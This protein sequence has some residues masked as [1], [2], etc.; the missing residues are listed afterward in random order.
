MS[1]VNTRFA[2]VLVTLLAC[3][4]ITATPFVIDQRD[5]DL[6]VATDHLASAQQAL[7]RA[8]RELAL[9]QDAYPLPG[10][11]Y[12]QMHA[13]LRPVEDTLKVLLSPNRKRHA[14]Q[15]V[16][17]DGIFFTPVMTGE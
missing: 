14:H 6:Q 17:P 4:S 7:A 10:L 8:Q 12:D 3:Q 16:V 15:T 13:Q 9:A 1:V 2:V 11:N 5:P